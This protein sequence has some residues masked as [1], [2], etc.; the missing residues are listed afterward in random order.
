MQNRW[1]ASPGTSNETEVGQGMAGAGPIVFCPGMAFCIPSPAAWQ[2]VYR[3]AYE[4]ARMALEPSRFQR[5]LKPS[6]N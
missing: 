5:M 1:A 2:A 3:A 4:Q 6:P